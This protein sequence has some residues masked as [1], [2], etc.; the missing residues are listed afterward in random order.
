MK[1]KFQCPLVK[2]YWNTFTLT[3]L[4]VTSISFH[5]V[6]TDGVVVTETVLILQ[7]PK[8]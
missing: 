4:H 5:Y 7:I 6:K 2:I 8:Y 3:G 1:F